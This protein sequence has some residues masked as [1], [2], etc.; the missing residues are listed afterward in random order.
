MST[1]IATTKCQNLK[2]LYFQGAPLANSYRSVRLFSES[3]LGKEGSTLFAEPIVNRTKNLI[4]WYAGAAGAVKSVDS[5]DPAQ[6]DEV[7]R[8]ITSQLDA[9]KAAAAKLEASLEK[10]EKDR[11]ELICKALS[12]A[13]TNGNFYVVGSTPVVTG[14]GLARADNSTVTPDNLDRKNSIAAAA[15]KPDDIIRKGAETKP[16]NSV[17]QEFAQKE[18]VAEPIASAA[19]LASAQTED[20]TK[21]QKKAF[22]WPFGWGWLKYLLWLLLLLLLMLLLWWLLRWFF[23]HWFGAPSFNSP[24]TTS[25][26]PY[27]PENRNY[28]KESDKTSAEPVKPVEEVKPTNTTVNESVP[29]FFNNDR[30]LFNSGLYDENQQELKLSVAFDRKTGKVTAELTNANEVCRAPVE[31]SVPAQNYL[32]L[33]IARMTCSKGDHFDPFRIECNKDGSGLSC[34]GQNKDIRWSIPVI[35]EGK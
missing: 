23:P 21:K 18:A 8:K 19:P 10:A 14:W 3:I 5:L 7:K 33:D 15:A 29:R 4:D 9:L 12:F 2:I 16:H 11:G 1:Y 30:L 35:V 32:V 28:V 13:E 25:S 31:V 24:S 17:A 27:K 20:A 6:A 34:I 26:A 22:V